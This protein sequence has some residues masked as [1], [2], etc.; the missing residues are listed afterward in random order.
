MK[1]MNDEKKEKRQKNVKGKNNNKNYYFKKF[2]RTKEELQRAE[3][4]AKLFKEKQRKEE[5][6]M[7]K[8]FRKKMLDKFAED[9]KIEQ[10]NAQKKRMKEL[11]HRKEVFVIL[12]IFFIIL[13]NYLRLKDYGK[14]D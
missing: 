9:D 7:E 5:E 11:E 3:K 12:N 4:E 8:D 10:M 6:Q 2:K 14:I 1:K 13:L